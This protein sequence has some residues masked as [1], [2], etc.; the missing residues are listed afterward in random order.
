MMRARTPRAAALAWLAAAIFAVLAPGC[1]GCENSVCCSLPGHLLPNVLR[2]SSCAQMGGTAVDVS[3]C[4]VI[5]CE[6]SD[7]TLAPSQRMSCRSVVDSRLCDVPDG[8]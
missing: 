3:M 1:S 2:P 5:C 4:D 7:G 8:G 6:A